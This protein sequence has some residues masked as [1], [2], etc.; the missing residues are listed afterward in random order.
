V[1][2]IVAEDAVADIE[3]LRLFLKDVNPAAAAR[4]VELIV[5]AIES[6]ETNPERGRPA[7]VLGLRELIVPFGRSAYVLRYAYYE[8]RSEVVII[9]VWH[10]REK[11]S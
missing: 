7:A 6:L 10:G 9:R 3:R 11:R 5:G 2:L 8:A 4:A 1:K